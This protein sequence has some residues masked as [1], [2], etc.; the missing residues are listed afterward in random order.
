MRDLHFVE[1]GLIAH[2]VETASSGTLPALPLP[3]APQFREAPGAKKAP[4]LDKN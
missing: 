4:P 3:I 2:T 1:R